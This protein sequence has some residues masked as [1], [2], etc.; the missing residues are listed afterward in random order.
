ML[1][2]AQFSRWRFVMREKMELVQCIKCGA[3]LAPNEGRPADQE[4][5]ALICD[6]D[7]CDGDAKK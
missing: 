5:K 3:V 4:T 6:E 1:K 2:G 7:G